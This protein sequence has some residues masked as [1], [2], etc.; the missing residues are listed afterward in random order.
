[1]LLESEFKELGQGPNAEQDEIADKVLSIAFHCVQ[2][3]STSIQA[4]ACLVSAFLG[5]EE[6]SE[7]LELFSEPQSKIRGNA[8][9]IS[10]IEQ[11][12]PL[13]TKRDALKPV[14]RLQETLFQLFR[15]SY[16]LPDTKRALRREVC[17]L[18]LRI[19]ELLVEEYEEISSSRALLALFCFDSARLNSK[20][21]NQRQ[22]VVFQQHNRKNW[23]AI[24]IEEGLHH[25]AVSAQE[26]EL[27]RY[28]LE[29]SIAAQHCLAG[30]WEETNWPA[31]RELYQELN[32]L[33]SDVANELNL[34][35]VDYFL[36]GPSWAIRELRKKM[37][38]ER[39]AQNSIAHATLADWLI[40][41]GER[42]SAQRHLQIAQRLAGQ[43]PQRCLLQEEALLL[44]AMN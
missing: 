35:I 37:K 9:C 15:I 38:D 18:V 14:R 32:C 36:R 24:Q 39:I 43:G 33:L 12:A 23:D 20:L 2:E 19:A 30:S 6:V 8:D 40:K 34:V 25:L 7:V 1:M 13:P 21:T 22:L 31:I 27:G 11:L 28:H 4:Q 3:N 26:G 29:A 42:E 10:S 17:G 44:G 16:D 5:P 41:G